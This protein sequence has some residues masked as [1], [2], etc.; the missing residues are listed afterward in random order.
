MLVGQAELRV[1]DVAG[2]TTLARGET[3]LLPA[4]MNRPTINA[5]TDCIWLEVTFPAGD[6]V[7]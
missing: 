5:I 2:V 4:R 6:E 7:K 1:D 3:V